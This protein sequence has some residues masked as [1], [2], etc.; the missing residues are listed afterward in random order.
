MP[1]M[2]ER[3]RIAGLAAILLA[4]LAPGGCYAGGWEIGA[5]ASPEVTLE[6]NTLG[7][8]PQIPGTTGIWALYSPSL[9]VECSPPRG[10]Y[11]KTQRIYYAFNCSPRY[12]AAMERISMDLNG[13]EI[14]RELREHVVALLARR[15]CRRH[16]GT[17][18]ALP[19]AG[20]GPAPLTSH[21][22]RTVARDALSCLRHP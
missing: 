3:F 5:G 12:A 22:P 2:P 10:C 21:R 15:R 18:N 8:S 19:V 20:T 6:M 16:Q 7:P 1:P 4:L 9:S 17:G 13:T 14:K 11:A